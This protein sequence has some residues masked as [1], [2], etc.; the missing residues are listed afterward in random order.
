VALDSIT[1]GLRKIDNSL[2]RPELL[3]QVVGSA[4]RD[5]A[6][7]LAASAQEVG[8]A[9][10]GER[11]YMEPALRH[12]LTERLGA[13]VQLKQ[14]HLHFK[15]FQGPSLIKLGGIDIGILREDSPG[16][17]AFIELKWGDLDWA[18]LDFFKMT[19]ARVSPGADS[20]Y[21]IA[22]EPLGE[23]ERPGSV[24]GFFLDAC[25]QSK[26]ILERHRKEFVG[27]GKEYGKLTHLPAWIITSLIA[28]EPVP[29][30]LNGWRIKAVRV[31]PEPFA[32]SNWLPLVDGLIE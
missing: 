26:G 9:K 25:W 11:R 6:L 21:V 30:P 4:V 29:E 8:K 24:G 1:A 16:Y 2:V 31:E 7:S 5:T 28:D 32:D 22:G 3:D 27:D 18:I 14:P 20:C 15:H 23:W 13:A 10:I 17:R 12:A 19:C